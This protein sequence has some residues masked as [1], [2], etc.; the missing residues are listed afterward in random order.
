MGLI[1]CFR[2]LKALIILF[3]F[4]FFFLMNYVPNHNGKVLEE[5]LADF[6]LD[7]VKTTWS[8]LHYFK[9][10]LPLLQVLQKSLPIPLSPCHIQ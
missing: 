3:L 6:D 7:A 2:I 1:D 8:G 10:I 5:T 4:I 9:M